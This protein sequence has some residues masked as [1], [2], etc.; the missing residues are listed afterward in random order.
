MDE[1]DRLIS[2]RRPLDPAPRNGIELQFQLSPYPTPATRPCVQLNTASTEA[3]A[4]R[5]HSC[6]GQRRFDDPAYPDLAKAKGST[7]EILQQRAATQPAAEAGNSASPLPLDPRRTT[8]AHCPGAMSL[9][10]AR[11]HFQAMRMRSTRAL[12]VAPYLRRETN[13]ELQATK[14]YNRIR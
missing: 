5:I 4:M 11:E 8:L 6:F 12:T 10:L 14:T 1:E 3:P 7:T 13:V 9:D 2:H